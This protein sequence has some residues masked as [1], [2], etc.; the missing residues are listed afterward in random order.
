MN[1]NQVPAIIRYRSALLQADLNLQNANIALQRYVAARRRQRRKRRRCMWSKNW[2]GPVRRR[3]FG[4]YD[5]L[6]VELRREDQKAFANFLRMPPAMFDEILNRVYPRIVKQTTWM[7]DPIAPGM[8]LA[9]TL[10]HLA[11]GAK[12]MDMRYGWRVPHNTISIIVRQVIIIYLTLMCLFC[13]L[14]LRYC[15]G[16]K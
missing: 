10:R 11:S 14:S 5:Q 1:C 8:K 2:L 12:Y 13:V 16:S 4:L 3:Q 6:M 9:I 15:D 7:R